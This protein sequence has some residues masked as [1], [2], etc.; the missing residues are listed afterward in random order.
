ML[1]EVMMSIIF[2]HSKDMMRNIFM[3]MLV[4]H[5]IYGMAA[6]VPAM[7]DTTHTHIN[8]T[9]AYHCEHGAGVNAGTAS[10][11]RGRHLPYSCIIMV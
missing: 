9:A 8:S 10:V 11:E 4:S 2:F 1:R 5:S 7:D 6:R 3:C